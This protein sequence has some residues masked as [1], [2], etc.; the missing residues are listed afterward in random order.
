[1]ETPELSAV[2][3]MFN[4]A[5]V[6]ERT[7][8]RV[9]EELERTGRTFEIVC[10]DDG[11]TDDTAA[12]IG[13]MA[14]SDPRIVSVSFSRNFGKEAAISAGLDVARGRAVLVLDA[15]LQHP[16]ELIPALLERWDAGYEVVD[17]VKA[18]RAPDALAR[19]ALARL[20]NAAIGGAIGRD[21]AGSS[22][23]KLL[24]RQV[25]EA[26][27]A[28]PERNRFFRG[29]VA[30]VGFR[31]ARVPFDVGVRAGGESKWGSLALVGYGLRNLVAFSAAPLRW[32]AWIG[33]LTVLAGTALAVQTFYNWLSGVA[34]TGFTTVILLQ[35]LLGGLILI[36][37]GVL[38]YYVSH[39]YE[40]QKA[41]P[42]F[43]VR[44]PAADAAKPERGT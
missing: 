20:F 16:P 8:G 19:R 25:V 1:M 34:L 39:V 7:V 26:L 31:V 42:V 23:F 21:L 27:R 44:K 10:I 38:G 30:W 14:R 3:P 4:E 13:A 41:R 18:S 11:S 29:L 2:L 6:L 43:V 12:R 22:D 15:D 35:Y 24:D 40:E 36:S 9:R 28:C 17:A 5:P 33:F 32:I 37:L